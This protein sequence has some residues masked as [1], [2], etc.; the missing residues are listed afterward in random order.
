MVWISRREY[1]AAELIV[2]QCRLFLSKRERDRLKRDLGNLR[3]QMRRPDPFHIRENAA[4]IIV[5]K[6]CRSFAVRKY[7]SDNGIVRHFRKDDAITYAHSNYT[8]RRVYDRQ[9]E[10]DELECT[11]ELLRHLVDR[12][13]NDLEQKML[14]FTLKLQKVQINTGPHTRLEA[15]IGIYGQAQTAVENQITYAVKLRAQSIAISE[16]AN[17]NLETVYQNYISIE[18]IESYMIKIESNGIKNK[19]HLQWIR[20]ER[21]NMI[22][23]MDDC[24]QVQEQILF[25]EQMRL[26]EVIQ[27]LVRSHEMYS[28]KVLM[29]EKLEGFESEAFSLALCVQSKRIDS[30]D[31]E[32]LMEWIQSNG[33][34]IEHVENSLA[35]TFDELHSFYCQQE[36]EMTKFVIFEKNESVIE[37]T[38]KRSS[39]SEMVK[40]D[41]NDWM[42][43]YESEPWV[44]KQEMEAALKH[45]KAVQGH[46]RVRRNDLLSR[47]QNDNN[48]GNVC[49]VDPA[50]GT[51]ESAMPTLLRS[52]I[53]EAKYRL[54]GISQGIQAVNERY[55]VLLRRVSQRKEKRK[56]GRVVPLPS[57]RDHELNKMVINVQKYMKQQQHTSVAISS[58]KFTVGAEETNAVNHVNDENAANGRPFYENRLELG[59]HT[60]VVLWIQFSSKD[61][62]CISHISLGPREEDG[63]EYHS[64]GYTLVGHPRLAG[65]LWVK[66]DLEHKFVIS[67]LQVT[68][69]NSS[70]S[71]ILQNDYEKIPCCLAALDDCL[72][73]GNIWIALNKRYTRM[74]PIDVNKLEKELKEYE[75]L[76]SQRAGDKTIQNLVEEMERRVDVAK[77][78]QVERRGIENDLEYITEFLVIEK[79]HI[80]KLRNIFNAIDC[81]ADKVVSIDEVVHFVKAANV[82][83]GLIRQLMGIMLDEQNR[84]IHQVDFGQFAKGFC[85]IIML[86]KEDMIKL[87][88]SAVDKAGYG[89]IPKKAYL[90]LLEIMDPKGTSV[91]SRALK[92]EFLP[93]S[94]PFALFEELSETYPSALF[95]LFQF[96]FSLREHLLGVKYW[97]RKIRKFQLAKRL[98]NEGLATYSFVGDKHLPV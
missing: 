96:Q 74:T 12:H 30:S 21:E 48:G 25:E 34:K 3:N 51:S 6:F 57:R 33:D 92:E 2:S 71:Q 86:G 77:R 42:R 49:K 62:E 50:Q 58:R 35:G 68:Y 5:Q 73:Q 40:F 41:S 88:F 94:L 38:C 64:L 47:K 18:S 22:R 23:L 37:A 79:S 67:S 53:K 52:S 43:M 56:S 15:R 75:E 78:R 59:H 10:I 54:K 14:T 4:A 26:N 76:L 69:A 27:T 20:D 60:Q 85:S 29:I 8:K 63:S 11:E 93:N 9:S 44:Q 46:I 87:V 80:K 83:S 72:V 31:G 97:N 28:T 45:L 66:R 81:D 90:D 55:K 95:P 89:Y 24:D 7:L 70:D 65:G 19:I 16:R 91:A 36:D 61:G 17:G 13:L 39:K 1:N 32:K 82:L 98:V 84:A